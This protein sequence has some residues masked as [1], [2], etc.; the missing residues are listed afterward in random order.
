MSALEQGCL[1]E[2]GAS[3]V[4]SLALR[5]AEQNGG[6]LTANH[7]IPYLPVSLGVIQSCLDDLVSKDT[8]VQSDATGPVTEYEFAACKKDAAKETGMLPIRM[9]LACGLDLRRT[10]ERRPFC[11][12]CFVEFKGALA[13]L[14][15][16]NGWPAQAIYEHE[17]LH[18]AAQLAGPVTARDLAAR[19][20]YS[21]RAVRGKLDA[22]SAGG[23]IEKDFDETRQTEVYSFP[24][25]EY[26]ESNYRDNMDIVRTYPAAAMEEARLR[27]F[28]VL[29][30]LGLE[31]VIFITLASLHLPFL[32]LIVLFLIAAPVTAIVIWRHERPLDEM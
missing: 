23:H 2:Q 13:R 25:I 19:S 15:D 7:L 11:Q 9:C 16:A 21:L 31:V 22:M 27:L 5:L 24:K 6:R 32:L 10:K 4:E 26:P 12:G 17:I 28:R 14:A 29:C 18:L 1:G 3:T 30:A 8:T 20:R